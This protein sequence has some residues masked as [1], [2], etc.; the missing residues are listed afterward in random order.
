MSWLQ[1]LHNDVIILFSVSLDS[2][3]IADPRKFG[4]FCLILFF[5]YK[6]GLEPSSECPCGLQFILLSR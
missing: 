1:T 3:S 5:I 6:Q 4:V 2:L